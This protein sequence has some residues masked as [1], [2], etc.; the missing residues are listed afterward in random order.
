MSTGAI[1]LP[2]RREFLSKETCLQEAQRV[3]REG[4]ICGMLAINEK[5]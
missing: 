1:H 4:G 2:V 3:L 5:W